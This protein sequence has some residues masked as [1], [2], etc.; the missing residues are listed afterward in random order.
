MATSSEKPTITLYFLQ[1]SRSIR[2]AWLLELLHLPYD[3]KFSP[4]LD[5]FKAAPPEFK[6]SSGN[7]LGKFPTLTD[8]SNNVTV[9]ESGAITDYLLSIY[10]SNSS[11]KEAGQQGDKK[12][13]GLAGKNVQE[14]A[15]I[16]TWIHA[17]EGTFMLHALS[18]LYATWNLSPSFISSN[19][20]AIDAMIAGM[21][22]NVQKDLDWLES[23]L[24]DGRD[25]LVGGRVTAAD[26][27]M[28]FSIDFILAREFGTKGVE[29]GKRWGRTGQWLERCKRD[30]SY[31]KAVE[32]SGYTLW[33]E[34]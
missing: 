29:V 15:Q 14:R 19:Q 20:S 24:S 33:P 12:S 11:D 21:S 3:L 25:W 13:L 5:R 10:D 31:R 7:P 32:R 23:E 1:A 18:I 8:S 26:V 4:R 22:V 16:A 30:E 2:T 28:Q 9:H 27:M 17:S 6:S 34:E